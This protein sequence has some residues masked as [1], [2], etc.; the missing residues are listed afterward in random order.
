MN[1]KLVTT[2][3]SDLATL[4]D[5]VT[6]GPE[7][8]ILPYFPLTLVDMICSTARIASKRGII[9]VDTQ[10]NEELQTYPE[11]LEQSG[12][13]MG[14]MRSMGLAKGDS[15]IMQLDNERNFIEGFWAC[16]LGGFIP[17]PLALPAGLMGIGAEKV[18]NVCRIMGNAHLLT[19]QSTDQYRDF[20]VLSVIEIA[21]LGDHAEDR[22]Y[23][24]PDPDDLAYLQFSSGSTGDPK[25]VMLSHRNLASN[26]YAIIRASANEEEQKLIDDMFSNPPVEMEYPVSTCSWLPLSHDMGLIG[27]HI[28]PLAV[29]MMQIKMGTTTF[30]VNPSLHLQLIHKHRVT[31]MASPNFGLSWMVNVV[32]DELIQGVDLSCVEI[33][34]NGAEPISG[35][36]VRAFVDRFSKYGFNPRAMFPVYGMAEATLMISA[37]PVNSENVFHHLD[38]RTFALRHMAVD[39]EGDAE[40]IEF[41]DEGYPCAGMEVRIV[42][43]EGNAVKETVAG[44]IQIK[45][46]HVTG[47]YYM[48]EKA[49]T[50]LFTEGWLKTGD[51]GFIREGRITVTGRFKDVIFVNGQNFYSEDIEE[52]LQQLPFVGFKN[53]AVCGITDCEDGNEKIILFMKTGK[54]REKLQDLLMRINESIGKR[55]MTGISSIVPMQDIPRTT[56]GKTQRY[57]M[58]EMYMQGKFEDREVKASIEIMP[59]N[60]PAGAPEE[61]RKEMD[62]EGFINMLPPA[63]TKGKSGPRHQSLHLF[64]RNLPMIIRVANIIAPDKGPIFV[65][66]EGNEELLTYAELLHNA[67]CVLGGLRKQGMKPGDQVIM[68]IEGTRDF[69]AGF[70][71]CILGGFLP[72][73]LP[74]P[75]GF[76]ISEGMERVAKV[77]ELLTSFCIITD[78]PHDTYASLGEVKIYTI[79]DLLKNVPDKKHHRPKQSD[80]ALLQFSSGSTG[81]P[82]GVM[83]THK[84]IINAIEAG[85]AG[86]FGVPDNDYRPIIGFILHIIRRKFHKQNAIKNNMKPGLLRRFDRSR[87]GILLRRW[88][89]SE[90]LL[91][92]LLI[93]SGK[94]ISTSLD[95][96]FDDISM[97]NWMPFSHV[98]GLIGFHIAPMLG[99]VYA[100]TLT[101]RT[102]IEKPALFLRLIDRYG[103]TH[104]PCPNFAAQWLTAQVKEEDMDRVDLSCVKALLNGSE[105][106][107]SMVT[108]DF[109]TRFSRYGLDPRTM[110]CAYGMSE[111]TVEI[112]TSPVMREPLFHRVDKEMFFK[113]KIAAP[114]ISPNDGIDLADV[115]SPIQ[116]LEVRITDE[117]D[118]VVRENMVGHIQVK[119]NTVAWR[120]YFNNP[121]ANENLFTTDGWL[122]TGD[123]GFMIGGRIVVA[124]RLKDIIFV[125]GQNLYSNDIEEHI[126]KVPGMAY[127]EFAVTGLRQY[128]SDSEK[129]VMFVRSG[130]SSEAMAVRLARIN[131]AL[132]SD[133]GIHID[134]LVP[135]ESIPR[136]PSA[137]IKRFKLR[138]NFEQGMYGE[139][140]TAEDAAKM[141]PDSGEAGREEELTDTEERLM[142]IWREVV[143]RQDIRKTDNFFDMGGNSLKATRIGSRVKEEFGIDVPLR[144]AF[145]NQ[146]VQS[147]SAAIDALLGKVKPG[148]E[149]SSLPKLV[150]V[151]K[152][153]YYE[154]SHAQKRLWYLDKIIPDSPF[155]NI[156]GAVLVENVEL[157]VAVIA[158]AMQAVAD[159]HETLRTVFHEVNGEPVQVISES[160]AIEVPV[161]DLQ[162]KEN[163]DGLIAEILEKE[164]FRPFNLAAG[165]LFRVKVVRCSPQKHALIIVMHHIISDGWSMGLLVQEAV[166]NYFA[167]AA[168]GAV[169]Q[170]KLAIQYRD[171]AAWQNRVLAGDAYDAQ[172]EYWL[173]DL[174]GELPVLELPYDRQRPVV[175]SQ[176]GK[177]FRTVMDKNLSRQIRESARSLDVTPFILT[178]AI[179]KILL[180]KLSRQ[181]DIII[182]TPI[183]GRNRSEIEPLI[184]FFVNVLPM[185]TVMTGDPV[186]KALV[187]SVKQTALGAYANQ[188]YPFDKLVEV[189]NPARNMSRSPIFDV[190]FEFIEES[191]YLFNNMNRN[192]IL[193]RDITGDD[194][195]AKFDIFLTFI[196]GKEGINVKFEYNADLFNDETIERFMKY[197]VNIA[198]SVLENPDLYISQISMLDAGEENMVLHEFNGRERDYPRNKCIHEI[199]QDMALRYADKAALVMGGET[200]TY[201]EL[202]ILSNRM[203]RHLREHGVGKGTHV[204]LMVEK[205]TAMLAAVLGILKAGGVYVPVD[206]EYPLARR[207]YMISDV[208]APVAIVQGSLTGNLGDFTGHTVIL[209]S[210]IHEC[211]HINGSAIT[212]VNDPDDD[213]N[214]IYTSGSTGQPKGV[215]VTHRGVTRLVINTDWADITENDRFAQ[216]STISF[217]AATMEFWAPL[218][219]GC[220]LFIARKEQVLSIESLA[221]FL[222]ENGISILF[223]TTVLYNQFVDTKPEALRIFK[224]ILV[225]GEAL[226]V[227]HVRKGLAYIEPGVFTNVYGP[228]ENTTFSTW[229]SVKSVPDDAVS[230]PIGYPIANST[231]YILDQY[232]KPVP[233]G[234]PGEIYVGGDGLARGYLNDNEKTAM[235]FIKNPVKGIADKILYKTGDLGK[236]LPDGSVDFL[237]RI[238]HQVKIR[239]HRIELGEIECAV[240][241]MDGVSDAVVVVKGTGD[242]NKILAAYYVSESEMP[243]DTIRAILRKDLPDY[244][245][246]NVFMRLG[247]LPLNRN[248][249]VDRKA[250]PEPDNSRPDMATEYMAPQGDVETAITAIWQDVLKIDKIGR[251]DN[252]FDLGGDSIISLQVVNR[253]NQ[254]GFSL[255]PRDLLLHQTI[256]ELAQIVD[257]K[258]SVEAEQGIVTGRAPLT[259]V[260]KWFFSQSLCNVNHFNQAL[261][262]KTS[263][264]LDDE[265]MRRCMEEILKHHDAL[266]MRFADAGQE[267]SAGEGELLF[268]SCR[269]ESQEELE[270]EIMRLQSSFDISSGPLFGMGHF[271]M[272]DTEYL[273]LTAHHLVVDGVSWRILMEDILSSYMSLM[274]GEDI[275]L[276]RKTTSFKEWAVK[277][278]EYSASEKVKKEISYWN[279][280]TAGD[281]GIVER[282]HDL[283]ENTMAVQDVVGISFT[284]EFTN[285]LL[286]EVHRTYNTDVNDLMLAALMKSMQEWTGSDMVYIDLEGHG[287][288]DVIDDVDIT[289]TVGWFTTIFPVVMRMPVESELS[290][291]IKYVKEKLHSIPVKGFNYG[292]LRF[293]G[294]LAETFQPDVSFNY[295]GQVQNSEMG[296]VFSLVTTE[297]AGVVDGKNSRAHLLDIIGIVVDGA[298]QLEFCY[299]TNHFRRGTI[300]TLAA[301]Y[302]RDL[303]DVV[304]HCMNM[305][306][307][308][309]TPSDFDLIDLKQE[310]LD[311]IIDFD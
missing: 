45:G 185:R 164:K 152:K 208:K 134:I 174:T 110:W 33:L 61:K 2:N 293:N 57:V 271:I 62:L 232:M 194:P 179:F 215:M 240:R 202:D 79:G 90:Y 111:A 43:D 141:L 192:E 143:D 55:I 229:Y 83:P 122:K 238:D 37:P 228:T 103:A 5:A 68:Q 195:N 216:L 292:L 35:S 14:A 67:R 302:K 150:P 198:S 219:N 279:E 299:S 106:I 213:C 64:I 119:G 307:Y 124:G 97:A 304:K 129:I 167:M 177:T 77:S 156:P 161:I 310:E 189:L 218:L 78:Q 125:N 136:T 17:V 221:E 23:H 19:D 148:E 65:D 63:I 6:S 9:Y 190:V 18:A 145:E 151:E 191:E 252:F 73:P 212:N 39:A 281:N 175:Q 165:P 69:L 270:R 186:F 127:I 7:L 118:Q 154:V 100:V 184:G 295:L 144:V 3:Q 81:D 146:T 115:G 71:G 231:L 265:L 277:L 16:I 237:G 32:K 155:Y 209:D 169:P 309:I 49:N 244:M 56:S 278:H 300:E 1:K 171:Y 8:N 130:E 183:A 257:M 251:S 172:K 162:G 36:A 157:D 197:Y 170:G 112:T 108:R 285:S 159:R 203:A 96:T 223:L 116:G 311:S 225:G 178:Q 85:T 188:D 128:E 303:E 193:L 241:A 187:E 306:N 123:M 242:Q 20:Q 182:G 98:M 276:P 38:R 263:L 290:S 117:N 280:L 51:L 114:T 142:R 248:G 207:N 138:D 88:K 94:K 234:V 104:I 211:G 301:F 82:K 296:E 158:R 268:V 76:P 99:A 284:P 283:G 72:A 44:H 258:K 4:P 87:A 131:K 21:G 308:D 256:A 204:I 109:L 297:V 274:K 261:L 26:I 245:I 210:F 46:P 267:N 84:N 95:I 11:L 286:R 163:Q 34:F 243:A 137:K 176:R 92:T 206:P 58:R 10:G 70:W 12:R 233:V 121:V 259:P 236:W 41:A 260:Q 25:G 107:S 89:A 222:T 180:H 66:T 86:V 75:G 181:D 27:F 217:D 126:K 273:M 255:Q 132:T 227:S 54:D 220:T 226:S 168:G 40:M 250:L 166:G 28:A 113:H 13:I 59:E 140:I 53:L 291:Q 246:P 254:R 173:K 135:V 253:L 201:G 205:S 80:A 272:K 22:D 105:P 24:R 74:V 160:I 52:M 294:E 147:L 101:P 224:K 199:F 282:D 102:F 47:G 214:I 262:F 153:E 139:Q 266:R 269:V 93:L 42:D 230:I 31:Q 305:E 287:R 133:I 200:M 264:R 15:V 60:E 91:D 247:S 249:K 275:S 29:S 120:G 239:G 30:V 149:K 288:E 289:R 298:M 196:E 50:E 235:T 48:N